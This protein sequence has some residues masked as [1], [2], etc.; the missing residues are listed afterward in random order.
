M[1]VNG[2][3]R[4]AVWDGVDRGG[5]GYYSLRAGDTL[6]TVTRVATVVEHPPEPVPKEITLPK[7]T[8]ARY[9]G[10]Y[11]MRPGVLMTIT[12]EGE[13]LVSQLPGQGKVPLF[14]ETDGKFFPKG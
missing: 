2:P 4:V 3:E 14:A 13:Q 1:T 10:K 11:E 5:K 8:L 12:V 9:A 6:D 7:E